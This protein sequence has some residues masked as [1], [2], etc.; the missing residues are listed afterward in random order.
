MAFWMFDRYVNKTY[1]FYLLLT[2]FYL[3]SIGYGSIELT[4]QAEVN[5]INAY[6]VEY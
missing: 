1:Y 4:V 5:Y 3:L 6:E 2:F